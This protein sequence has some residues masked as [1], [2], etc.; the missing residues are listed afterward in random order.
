M[1]RVALFFHLLGALLFFSGITVAGL[2]SEVARRRERASDVA[3]LLSISRL[4][5]LLVA[6]GGLLLPIFGLWLVHL[7]H[8]GYGT[9]WIDWA[10]GLY[11]LAMLLGGVGGRRPKRA[12][13]CATALAARGEPVNGELASLLE[14]RVSRAVNYASLLVVLAILVLMV[15][16]P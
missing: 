6:V 13:L 1:Y 3:V 10:I 9:G 16:K 14:D 7:G 12:R 4:G 8:W 5:A 2:A 15:F 11:V